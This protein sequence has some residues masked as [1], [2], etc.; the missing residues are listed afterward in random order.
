MVVA[1]AGP[2]RADEPDVSVGGRA[3]VDPSAPD[4]ASAGGPVP[5][6]LR[7]AAHVTV[8]TVV[9]VPTLVEVADGWRPVR[10]D[11][12]ISIGAW[13]VFTAHSPL[14]GPWSLASGTHY[15][16]FDLGPLLFWLLAL[17]VHLD[18]GHGALWGAALVSAAALSVG[19]E[20][21]WRLQ[22]WAAA[23]VMALVVADLGWSTPVFANLAW[24]PYV[25]LCVLLAA[26]AVS[27]SVSA[28]RLG[29]WPVAVLFASVAAQCHLVYAVAAAG[30]VL[31]SPLAGLA[32]RGRPS[33]WRW[34][35]AGLLVGTLCWL[36]TLVQEVTGSPG[37]LS[38]VLGS[39]TSHPPVGLDFGLHALATAASPDPIWL[40]R[41][42]VLLSFGDRMPAYF[43]QHGVAWAV[44]AIGAVLGVAIGGWRAGRRRLGALAV[45]TLVVELG[46]VASF[47][48]FP[49]DDLG[50]SGYL[51]SILWVVGMLVWVTVLWA[52]AEVVV[53][54]WGRRTTGRP[55]RHAGRGGLAG[56]A[57]PLTAVLLLVGTSVAALRTVVPAASGQ[58]ANER[59][60]VPL[61]RR[62]ATAVEDHGPRSG[63]TFAVRPTIFRLRAT[64]FG[65][66]A[67][68]QWG[69]AMALL[70]DGWNPAVADRFA[71]AATHLTVPPDPR[72]PTVVVTLDPATGRVAA[73]GVS[74]P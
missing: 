42:P 47:A 34:L 18:P 45:V 15:P 53:H 69:T 72:W 68:D 9:L 32:I 11:A 46:T 4:P 48:A 50:P 70:G 26:V 10:D 44:V 60:D 61:D 22:G 13:Q 74:R 38:Q 30:L 59:L 27:W 58:V 19:V 56:W 29:W 23:V 55:Q 21:V 39:R 71:A 67:V 20:A 12:M 16:F 31:V 33:R 8:W 35:P 28:G 57:V 1:E 43:G 24:N 37:N 14:V 54:L 5:H 51:A 73:V 66:Y 65:V 40:G 49:K 62:I 3:L 17:P 36:P 6:L 63:L 25:G 64:A 7:L 41:L 52:A 2:R